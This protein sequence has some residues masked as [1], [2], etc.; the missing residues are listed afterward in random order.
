MEGKS[1]IRRLDQG[2]RACMRRS[3][4]LDVPDLHPVTLQGVF[5]CLYPSIVEGNHTA[6]SAPICVFRS[7]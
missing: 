7:P 1:N 4:Q 5:E 3:T 6:S 2:G